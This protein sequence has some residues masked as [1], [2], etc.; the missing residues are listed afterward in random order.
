MTRLFGLFFLMASL[1]STGTSQAG[2]A[3]AAKPDPAALLNELKEKYAKAKYYNIEAIEEVEFRGDLSRQWDK[4]FFGAV[5]TSGN[6]YR[7]E[8]RNSLGWMTK[9]SDGHS[10][11]ILDHDANMYKKKAASGEGPSKFEGSIFMNQMSLDSAQR[12]LSSITRTLADVLQ[13]VLLEDETLMFG[14]KQVPCYVVSSPGRYRGGSRDA[15]R[16]LTL[17]IDKETHT[18]RKVH[19]H[20]E[21]A[22]MMNDPYHR[23]VEDE[24]TQYPVADLNVISLPEVDFQFQPPEGPGW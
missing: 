2:S 23:E 14:G 22:L 20:A 15:T 12:L 1:V 4:S 8:G 11:W 24:T 10:E 18:V 13:P 9:I 5:M 17:W 16:Q 21:G 7:F 3:S 19:Q 6:R